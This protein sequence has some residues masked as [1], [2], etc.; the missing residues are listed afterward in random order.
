MDTAYAT[1]LLKGLADGINPLTGER[2][3]ME[4]SCNQPDIIRALHMAV[5]VMEKK[6]VKEKVLPENA[7]K[8]WA[9][10]DDK[11]L[12]EMFDRGCS[13]KE[14]CEHFKRTSGAI[15]AR[16]VRIGKIKDRDDW[17]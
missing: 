3:S 2:L 5:A 6:A 4:D 15:A 12:G 16:L 10:E 17:L 14:L 11:D 9:A 8:S 13:R 1:E 7:G